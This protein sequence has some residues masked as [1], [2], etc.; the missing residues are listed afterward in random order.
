VG[1]GAAH[2][3]AVALPLQPDI[4]TVLAV[5]GEEAQVFHP[6]QALAYAKSPHG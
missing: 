2:H 4:V 5:A 1:E 6:A 3:G